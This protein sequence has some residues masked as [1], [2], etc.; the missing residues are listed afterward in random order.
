MDKLEKLKPRLDGRDNKYDE[1]VFVNFGE[2]VSVIDNVGLLCK[3]VVTEF[4]PSVPESNTKIVYEEGGFDWYN[5]DE[6]ESW[7]R[8]LEVIKSRVAAA[9]AQ[10]IPETYKDFK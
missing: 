6:V 5:R 9:E 1:Y 10:E 8:E 4:D 7:M 2:K 3:G